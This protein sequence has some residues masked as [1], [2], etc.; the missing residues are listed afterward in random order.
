MERKVESLFEYTRLNLPFINQSG[1]SSWQL[2]TKVWS[3]EE[4]LGIIYIEVAFCA[5]GEDAKAEKRAQD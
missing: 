4:R 2:A 3:S 1:I 5:T